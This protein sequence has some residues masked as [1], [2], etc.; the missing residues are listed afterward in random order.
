MKQTAM[1]YLIHELYEASRV[2]SNPVIT[3]TIN[4]IIDM[5][6]SKLEM[7]KEQ[8]VNACKNSIKTCGMGHIFIELPEQYYNE[9]YK[10]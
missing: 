7:E 1:Q 6:E 9:T 2:S 8:I 4:L 3:T 5:A 10:K